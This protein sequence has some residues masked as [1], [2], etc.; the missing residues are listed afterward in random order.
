MSKEQSHVP[1]IIVPNQ[2]ELNEVFSWARLPICI[3]PD[4]L[5]LVVRL[6]S[7]QVGYV[8]Y[9]RMSGCADTAIIDFLEARAY[10]RRRGYG[11]LLVSHLQSSWPSIIAHKVLR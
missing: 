1:E 10:Y 4:S 6:G 11:R 3:D 9:R 5:W 8:R 2:K 7:K